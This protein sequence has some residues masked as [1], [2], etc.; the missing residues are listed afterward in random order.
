MIFLM[1]S[2]GSVGGRNFRR[3]KNFIRDFADRLDIGPNATQ[4]GVI[5]FNEAA[6]VGF[7]LSTF[8]EK[9]PLI[10]GINDLRYDRGY[11][12][13][14]DAL[15]LLLEEGF[16]EENG[17]RLTA[18]DVFSIAIVITDGVSNRNSS[19]CDNATTYDA[20]KAVHNSSHRILVFAI[21]I[22][23]GVNEQ[24]LLAIASKEEYVTY[25]EDF[26]ESAFG[27][28]R[29]EQLY[30]LCTKSTIPVET[31]SSLTGSLEEGY[32]VRYEL[33]VPP[34]FKLS[35]YV[36]VSQGEI[37]L[38]GSSVIPNPNS[39]LNDFNA[40][41]NSTSVNPC[42]NVSIDGSSSGSQT[43]QR[44]SI[45]VSIEGLDSTNDYTLVTSTSELAGDNNERGSGELPDVIY[46]TD[47]GF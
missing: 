41:V 17:A 11:T 44:D 32:L 28:A 13:T 40:S 39:A 37:Q 26:N 6:W 35:L 22:T 23:D 2:S 46:P 7:H 29:D 30:D 45:F 21:G 18:A 34:Q 27:T 24:E 14:A 4:V 33:Q 15:C 9:A 1:D 5:L 19:R 43:T 25:L 16:S 31:S 10:A 36:C 42:A 20:A 12:N 8:S 3:M 38:Y 47:G